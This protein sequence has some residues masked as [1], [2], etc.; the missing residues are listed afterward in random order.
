M[1]IIPQEGMYQGGKWEFLLD[2]PPDYPSNPPKVLCTTQIYH[3][4]I[5]LQG[6]VCLSI[7]RVDGENNWT[8]ILDFNSLADG[9]NFLFTDPNPEDPLNV[10]AGEAMKSN[11][12]EFE[13]TVKR[14][15]RGGRFFG[16][17]FPRLI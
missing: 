9:L 1:T 3:P 15:L 4:N 10:E 11:L 12:A 2:C 17:D 5:D 13:R 8:P 16:K 6:N 14:T 7:L